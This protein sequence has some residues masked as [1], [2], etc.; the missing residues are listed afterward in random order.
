MARPHD[1]ASALTLLYQRQR[2]MGHMRVIRTVARTVSA[3]A[4]GG[5]VGLSFLDGQGFSA[6]P[7]AVRIVIAC[8]VIAWVIEI[9]HEH[10]I[11]SHQL[12]SRM[13]LARVRALEVGLAAED[14]AG[15]SGPRRRARP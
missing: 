3:L 14:H 6:W 5:F 12:N 11:A 7:S 8:G 15:R 2:W 9:V 4:L 13:L 1:S 10:R